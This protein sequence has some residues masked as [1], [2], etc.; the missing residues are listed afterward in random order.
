MI[1]REHRPEDAQHRVERRV[2][3][4]QGF[5]I[6]KPELDVEPFGHRTRA[7]A[8]EQFGNIVDAEDACARAGRRQ[9]GVAVAARHIQHLPARLQAGR[10]GQQ[11]AD[12][13]DA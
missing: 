10:I 4:G 13:H 5:G 1:G 7:S 6:A 3:H 9:G 2:R 12:Q 8:L 11:F